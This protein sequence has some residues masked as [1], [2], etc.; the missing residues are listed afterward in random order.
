M[1]RCIHLWTGDDQ[2]SHF[3]EGHI[4]LDPGQ[5]GD[6]LTGKL[7]TASVSFQETKSGGAFA[8]HTAPARQLVITLSGTL[9]F[10]TR[11]GRHFRLHPGDIL[12]AEDTR[13]SGHSWTL[14]DDQPWRR[15]Y[16]ILTP[17]ASVPFHPRPAGG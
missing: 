12:F 5:R 14:V 1:I 7:A 16:V 13:G 2:Q 10:Q 15:A 11:E 8:W 17:T 3:E 6:L 4:A 9:D